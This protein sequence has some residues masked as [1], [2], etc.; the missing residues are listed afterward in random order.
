[1]FERAGST[2]K[3]FDESCKI[4]VNTSVT[5][6]SEQKTTPKADS[7]ALWIENWEG[8]EIADC[9]VRKAI[10]ARDSDS[11]KLEITVKD[12]EWETFGFGRNREGT[13]KM[14][15]GAVDGMP[16]E[17]CNF[18]VGVGIRSGAMDDE[19]IKKRLW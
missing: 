15:A 10:E 7:G 1:L 11:A 19:V 4:G 16:D 2:V 14:Q 3:R 13:E 12:L 5:T 17:I 6:A 18:G 8:N 9:A